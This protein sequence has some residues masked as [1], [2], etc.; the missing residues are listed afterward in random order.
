M[1]LEHFGLRENPFSLTPDP[2][3]LVMTDGH[4]EALASMIYGIQERRGFVLVVGEVGTGKTTLIRHLLGHFGDNIRTCYILNT[5]VSFEEL[6]EAILRDLALSCPSRLRL[7]MIEAL[8]EYLIKEAEAGRY[9]VLLLDEAQHLSSA[10]LEDLRMLSNL[11]TSQSKLLQ[12]ILVGQPELVDKLAQPGLRQ[13]RQRIA[14][15]AELT[16]LTFKETT[17]YIDHRL[18]VAGRREGVPFTWAALRRIYSASGGIPRLVNLLSDKA[19]VLAFGDGVN[20]IRHHIVKQAAKERNFSP[21]TSR[22]MA[23]AAETPSALHPRG[24]PVF[25]LPAAILVSMAVLAALIPAVWHTPGA[26]ERLRPPLAVSTEAATDRVIAAAPNPGDIEAPIVAGPSPTA[27]EA[28]SPELPPAAAVDVDRGGEPAA[29]KS[30]LR[31]Q[32]PAR[33]MVVKVDRGREPAAPKGTLRAQPR[34]SAIVVRRGDTLASILRNAYGHA[35]LTL[36]DHVAMANPTIIDINMLDAAQRL[37]L[38]PFNPP[39]M[40]HQEGKSLYLV[41][42]VTVPSSAARVLDK[43]RPAVTRRGRSMYEVEVRLTDGVDAHRVYIGDF[44]NRARAEEFAR[45]FRL[46]S[47]LSDF[48]RG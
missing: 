46:P 48:L 6:L 32:P 4:K 7:D 45:S 27:T 43:L 2:R 38:P 44:D 17:Q 35:P 40:V 19:L 36:V 5:L 9:V 15:I 31:A 12:I 37:R 23:A 42:V 21:R 30:T 16:P 41:H 20:R 47:G 13:L 3:Y 29:P 18:R 26:I 14:L 33:E 28:G 39:A 34:A 22:P 25:R 11:E 10:V 8:N 24:W 1:Y